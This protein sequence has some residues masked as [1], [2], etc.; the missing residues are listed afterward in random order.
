MTVGAP[1]IPDPGH[2]PSN[3]GS[4]ASRPG[5]RYGR[6]H[7]SDL[8]TAHDRSPGIRGAISRFGP[9][10]G[11]R[12]RRTR[13]LRRRGRRRRRRRRTPRRSRSSRTTRA[14]ADEIRVAGDRRREPVDVG[15][16]EGGDLAERVAVELAERQLDVTASSSGGPAG[17]RKLRRR[18]P[19]ERAGRRAR[20]RRLAL[21]RRGAASGA[22]PRTDAAG[23]RPS[24]DRSG[25]VPRPERCRRVDPAGDRAGRLR[26]AAGRHARAARRSRRRRL[27]RRRRPPSASAQRRGRPPP[28]SAPRRPR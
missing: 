11:R 22:W 27:R 19:G 12:V 3:H 25:L 20:P 28:A 10:H 7:R 2:E 14:A 13:P 8:D 21:V 9:R 6:A 18:R 4:S 5:P 23:R 15:R 24:A 16:L 17:G 1:R 26:A